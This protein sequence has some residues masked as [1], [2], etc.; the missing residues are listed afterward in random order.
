MLLTASLTLSQ[1]MMSIAGFILFFN[2]L[3]EGKFRAKYDTLRKSKGALAFLLIY[4][5]HIIG[6]FYTHNFIFAL[7]D[8]R[9]KLPLLALPVIF[10]TTPA[11]SRK[12]LIT[13]L[14]VYVASTF[15]A[16]LIG[17]GIYFT[18]RITDIRD[19]SIFISHIRFSLNICLAIFILVFLF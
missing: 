8:L 14:L 11:V 12:V 9:I 2:W 13:I 3:A 1:G 15:V 10:V 4:A 6:L 17:I 19:I 5:I 18:N 16:S 7:D